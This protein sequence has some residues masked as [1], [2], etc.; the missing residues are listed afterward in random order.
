MFASLRTNS[1]KPCL[2][3]SASGHG[4]FAQ[5]A[6]LFFDLA[7]NLDW[8]V[9]KRTTL[10]SSNKPQR[11]HI[12][13]VCLS[14]SIRRPRLSSKVSTEPTAFEA[15]YG[16]KEPRLAQRFESVPPTGTESIWV[17]VYGRSSG[18]AIQLTKLSGYNV[19][20]VSPG[21]GSVSRL[22][23]RGRDQVF[24]VNFG[25]GVTFPTVSRL[26]SEP[27]QTSRVLQR[28]K[29]LAKSSKALTSALPKIVPYAE[30]AK[31]DFR[32]PLRHHTPS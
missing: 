19:V 1:P 26:D 4:A 22:G 29:M 13:S 25:V 11:L 16:A 31:Y 14:L 15:L 3:G 24:A 12:F 10:S 27:S 32:P 23:Q 20:T 9:P 8:S 17:F 30:S 28:L 7:W 2:L 6:K 18:V 21:V 5:Y